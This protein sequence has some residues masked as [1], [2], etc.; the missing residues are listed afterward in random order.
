MH[1]LRLLVTC[2]SAAAAF[3]CN[4]AQETSQPRL[5]LLFAPCTVSTAFLSPYHEEVDF[6]P[7]LQ[8]FAERSVV[9]LRHQT[10]VG[11]SGP[12]YAAIFSGGQADHHQVY[13]L[14]SRL[15]DE[16]HV[17]AETFAE[18]GYETFYW[19]AHP[20]AAPRLHFDQGVAEGNAFDAQLDPHDPRFQEILERL[21]SDA[22]YKA[23]VVATSILTHAPYHMSN[24][25]AFHEQ[26]PERARGIDL[27]EARRF[28]ELYREKPF[29]LTWNF[30]VAAKRLNLSGERLEKLTR[31]VEL[32]YASNV[33]LVDAWFGSVLAEIDARDLGDESLIA[34]T[35]DHGEVMYRENSPFKWSH[36][37]QL[38][39]E[40]LNVPL[41]IGSPRSSRGT[42][43]G[44]TRSIDVFPTLAGLSG[45]PIP[46]SYGVQGVDL[47]KA[48]QGLEPAPR[49]LAPSH[50]AVLAPSVFKQMYQPRWRLGWAVARGFFPQV[51]RELMWVSMRDGDTIYKHQKVDPDSWELQ[52]FDLARDPGET[53]NLYD[54]DDP[55]HVEM[56][57][58]LADY[59][60][61]LVTGD[62]PVRR[63]DPTQLPE[64]EEAELLRG[65]GYIQ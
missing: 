44:V 11:Q 25:E 43:A 14:P 35:A 47:S 12:A 5:V 56:A 9:F 50:T 40:V 53:T 4:A 30:E 22:S 60:A 32:L 3:G 23:F 26:Y 36:G 42:Y 65:L 63:V 28:A 58:K 15:P 41:I 39:P 10:E 7:N 52:V 48:L 19:A 31:A 46:A 57:E 38:A 54:P 37:L 16:V 29:L 17:V 20:A 55:G 64:K 45:I 8:A 59:K 1:R 34:F 33:N 2:A 61:R 24:W 49:L 62:S 6:T 27:D 18:N 21:A 51:D 13:S